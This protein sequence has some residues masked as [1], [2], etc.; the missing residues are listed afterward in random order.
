[1]T[2]TEIFEFALTASARAFFS[3]SL[4][5]MGAQPDEALADTA[6]LFELVELRQPS[7]G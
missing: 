6:R 4:D 7:A 2:D 1:L 3:K 5:S